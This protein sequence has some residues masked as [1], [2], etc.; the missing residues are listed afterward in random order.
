MFVAII[1]PLCNE[2]FNTFLTRLQKVL[3]V[4]KYSREETIRGNTVNI[5]P[6]SR[7]WFEN[8]KWIWQNYLTI[9]EQKP[10]YLN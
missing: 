8:W 4:E 10:I 2:N 6:I 3:K 1:V 9:F 5:L 7:S